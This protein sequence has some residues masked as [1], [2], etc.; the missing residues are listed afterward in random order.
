MKESLPERVIELA[1]RLTGTLV[2]VFLALIFVFLLLEGG[3]TFGE[4]DLEELART[5]WYPTEGHFGLLPLILGSLLVTLGAAAVSLPLGVLT[6]VFVAE[7]APRWIREI[8]KPFIE[9]LAGIPSVVYGFWGLVVLTPLIRRWQP[10]GQSLLAGV[11]ILTVMILPTITLLSASALRAV[12]HAALQAAAATGLSRWTRSS[13]T[14]RCSPSW[15]RPAMR[16]EMWW[17]AWAASAAASAC[18]GL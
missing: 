8:L 12:P 15:C 6:A 1:I 11:L 4:V 10:P 9:V 5:R 16:G 17:L 14:S 2:I 7:V 18:F 3:A 13:A